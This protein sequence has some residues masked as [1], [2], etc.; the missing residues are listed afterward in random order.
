VKEQPNSRLVEDGVSPTPSRTHLRARLTLTQSGWSHIVNYGDD[1]SR[2]IDWSRR[3]AASRLLSINPR[4]SH[5]G[6][7]FDGVVVRFAA[8][9]I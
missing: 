7:R 6:C 8:W 5:L 9:P 1:V 3:P 4:F 2:D